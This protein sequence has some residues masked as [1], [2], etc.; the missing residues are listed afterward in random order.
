MRGIFTKAHPEATDAAAE[1]A[2]GVDMHQAP[3][4][5]PE[6][7][8][9][10][11]KVGEDHSPA[12]V[13]K[14]ATE[15]AADQAVDVYRQAVTEAL[16]ETRGGLPA[17][18]TSYSRLQ[19]A[20]KALDKLTAQG[21][22][23][24]TDK[25]GKNWN[26]ASYVEMATRTAVSQRYDDLQN[27][28]LERAGIDLIYTY[29]ISTEG[30]CDLCLPWLDRVLSLSGDTVGNVGVADAAGTAVTHMVAGSLDE[31][32]AAGFRHPQCRCEWVP[33]TDGTDFSQLVYAGNSPTEAAKAYE[34]SQAQRGFE[35]KV[36]AAASRA[37]VAVTPEAKAK[38]KADLKAAKAASAAHR[39][40][41]GVVMTQV[42]VRRRE[43][44]GQAR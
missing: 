18:S 24:Y 14:Q 5:P 32:R 27:A 15:T 30:S 19:A 33:Y 16:D 23:G 17:T 6:A 41:A 13:I 9:E 25:A 3:G 31:A 28:A 4:K 39:E 37:A 29:T 22:T 44:A 35:R 43:R 10:A 1:Q 12:Q 38:A 34:A 42:G 8:R 36:R 40:S 7:G 21:I 20:Q 11:P 26:L 2:P